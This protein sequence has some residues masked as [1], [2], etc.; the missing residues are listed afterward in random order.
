MSEYQQ[1]KLQEPNESLHWISYNLKMLVKEVQ[2]ANV[3]LAEL[4]SVIREAATPKAPAEYKQQ[5]M[6]F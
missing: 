4:S 5:D 6:P 1:R 2:A 3:K